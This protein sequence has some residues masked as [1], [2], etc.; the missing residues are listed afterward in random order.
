MS[1]DQNSAPPPPLPQPTS[2]ATG[3]IIP[4]KNPHALMAYYLGVFSIIPALGFLLACFAVP[5]GVIGLRKRKQHPHLKGTAHAWVGIIIGGLSLLGH[6]AI[7]A[8]M[9]LG[10]ASASDSY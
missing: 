7:I 5:L 2:D 4:Y 6:L 8:L 1:D 9:I 3:G 10:A